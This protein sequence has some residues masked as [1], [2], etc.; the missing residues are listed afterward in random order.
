MCLD[1]GFQ[2]QTLALRHWLSQTEMVWCRSTIQNKQGNGADLTID[3][4]LPH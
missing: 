4:D 1:F 3:H 2:E